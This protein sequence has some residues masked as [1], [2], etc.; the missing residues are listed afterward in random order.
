MAHNND[1]TLSIIEQVFKTM[2]QLLDE[3][4]RRLLAASIAKGYGHGGIKLVSEASGMDIRTIRSGIHEIKDG[5]P[6]PSGPEK[7]RKSGAGRKPVKQLQPDLLDDIR[8]VVEN[9]TYGDPQK[10]ISWT[11][12]SLRDISSIL[13][14]RF[15]IDAGKDIVSRALEE[16]GYSKQANQKNA[17]GWKPAH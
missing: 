14:E 11:D 8:A 17:P 2:P 6:F 13:K 5:M 16:L 4:Q 12:L 10:V 15:G 3:R 9:N 7:V 1:K